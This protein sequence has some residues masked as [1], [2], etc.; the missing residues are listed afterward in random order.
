M[1]EIIINYTTEIAAQ[2]SL[3]QIT[4]TL[5]EFGASNISVAYDR[6]NKVPSGVSFVVETP[7]G[8][9]EFV[10]PARIERVQRVLKERYEAGDRRIGPRHTTYEHAARVAWR[11][12]KDWIEAQIAMVR[13]DLVS[14]DEIFF[15]RMIAGSKGETVYELFEERRPLLGPGKEGS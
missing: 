13:L 5:V 15:S 1:P 8:D 6:V 7:V 9:R 14:V 10:L 3:G 4:Q 11:I 12:L 2:K